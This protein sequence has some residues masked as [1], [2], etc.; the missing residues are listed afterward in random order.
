MD[1]LAN[2][3]DT[4]EDIEHNK[5]VLED[6]V[7]SEVDNAIGVEKEA[8]ALIESLAS[9]DDSDQR[10]I[11]EFECQRLT[12]LTTEIEGIMASI[13]FN[14]GDKFHLA[15]IAL[16]LKKRAKEISVKANKM[17]NY[18]NEHV[19]TSKEISDFCNYLKGNYDELMEMKAE[20]SDLNVEMK[21]KGALK[22]DHITLGLIQE[23]IDEEVRRVNSSLNKLTNVDATDD[24][25]DELVRIIDEENRRLE[26]YGNKLK[27]A[28]KDLS[29][30][31]KDFKNIVA[32][33]VDSPI[34]TYDELPSNSHNEE[35]DKAKDADDYKKYSTVLNKSFW[36]ARS[37]AANDNIKYPS[38]LFEQKVK[39]YQNDYLIKNYN[40]SLEELEDSIS[41]YR[42]KYAEDVYM[43]ELYDKA[44]ND[45]R[46][47]SS[48][49]VQELCEEVGGL[50][51]VDDRVYQ[52]LEED[53]V[54]IT[55][56]I[57]K[58]KEDENID[59]SL[60]INEYR[61]SF[62]VSQLLD[63]KEMIEHQL[64]IFKKRAKRLEEDI[65]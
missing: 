51:L 33:L 64:E 54:K 61:K 52:L 34:S 6:K 36:E 4:I 42:D 39:E 28:L 30:G 12:R 38:A 48:A 31:R 62:K 22:E 1:A 9:N 27:D 57:A 40:I 35:S 60:A 21:H 26:A 65:Y 46:K 32:D 37:L 58:A 7:N 18:G 55:K 11:L 50:S 41:E 20:I 15:D 14:S 49:S 19:I 45:L 16:S 56:D 17:L 63:H 47:E 8:K 44:L 5:H 23:M 3:V 59:S 10:R 13:E 2:N 24:G 43:D 53:L 29:E 25:R